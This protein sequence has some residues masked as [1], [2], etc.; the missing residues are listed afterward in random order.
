MGVQESGDLDRHLLPIT[1]WPRDEHHKI[2]SRSAFAKSNPANACE[3][4]T[5]AHAGPEAR[6]SSKSSGDPR[7]C[8]EPRR[9]PLGHGSTLSDDRFAE[10]ATEIIRERT[11]T[12]QY[13]AQI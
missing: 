6:G 2:V 5:P 13:G 8:P 7:R 9:S 3:C 11:T 4:Y 12:V 1:R 10:A